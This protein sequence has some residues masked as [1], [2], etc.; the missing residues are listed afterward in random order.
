MNEY[1]LLENLLTPEYMFLIGASI[2]PEIDINYTDQTI[3]FN[4]TKT[5][6]RDT[7]S[8]FVSPKI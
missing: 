8:S 7:I 4:T 5:F 3:T 1:D 6:D 2:T